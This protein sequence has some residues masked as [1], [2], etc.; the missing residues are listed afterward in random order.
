M[1]LVC[2]GYDGAYVGLKG[3][4][5]RFKV[6][7][8]SQKRNNLFGCG[9]DLGKPR[10]FDM[11]KGHCSNSLFHGRRTF[12]KSLNIQHHRLWVVNFRKTINI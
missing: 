8:S 11:D 5:A 6:Y 7:G 10:V 12:L 4:N 2:L 9:L 1:R 3:E